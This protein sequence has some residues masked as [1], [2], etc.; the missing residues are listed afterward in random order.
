MI[1]V[2]EAKRRMMAQVKPLPAE[3]LP[4]IEC[5]DRFTTAAI[6]APCDHPL[7][8]MS[9]V[10]GYAF[11]FD[12]TSGPW[13]VVA[14][15]AA[16]DV[17]NKPVEGGTC[18]RIFTGALVP[19]GTDTVVMQEFVT[20]D[21]DRITHTDARL[22]SGGNVRKQGEQLR[23]GDTVF[24]LGTQL[25]PES[26]GLLASIGLRTAEVAKR[27]RAQVIITGNEFTQEPAPGRIF[28][29]NDAML[30][31]AM[32]QAGC[33][34]AINHGPDDRELLER[35]IT[36]AITAGDVLIS[37]GGASVG[38]HDLVADAVRTLGGTIHFH[39][40][41]QKPGK[42]MLFATIGGVP[43]FGLP[44]NPRAVM[45]LFREYLLPF[46]RA[47]QGASSPW[48]ITDRLP[49]AHAVAVKGDRAEFRAARVER[50]TVTLLADEGSHMLSTLT[51]ADALAYLPDTVRQFAAGDP[52][53]IH[54]L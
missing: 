39:G 49:L 5:L 31:A 25:S 34:V 28:S 43:F 54:Y 29:S 50:G 3:R 44:G 27:P 48:P 16:G 33:P 4:L 36:A 17:L 26:L 40:V 18:V 11:R 32:Q 30:A 8:D 12:G 19:E 2:D 53:E 15:L 45:V 46:L 23:T 38:E 9:A 1:G 52:V 21:G 35:A 14:S 7:F 51:H 37:T 10:D 22:V 47:M 41:A 6:A 24:P 20:R 42:P 13:P